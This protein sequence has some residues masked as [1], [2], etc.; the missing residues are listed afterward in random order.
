MSGFWED[1]KDI[2]KSKSRK[3]EEKQQK[4]SDVLQSENELV[5]KLAE[6]EEAYKSSLP[7]TEK[8]NL[9]EL[10]PTSLGLEKLIYDA[11]TDDELEERAQ[12]AVDYEKTAAK[13]KLDDSLKTAADKLS[14]QEKSAEKNLQDSYKEL[15][16]LYTDLKKKAENN[17]IKRGMARSSVIIGQLGNLD[18]AHMASAGEVE[19]AYN[20]I[21]SSINYEI[22]SLKEKKEKAYD[23]LDLKYAVELDKKITSLKSERDKTVADYQKY[24]NTIAEKET[25]Y[26]GQRE[27]DIAAYL[28]QLESDRLKSES[29]KREYEAQYGY[30]GAKQENYSQ[31]YDLAY[32]FYAS[33]SP[34]IAAAA[35]EAS[36][37]MRYYLGNYYDKLLSVLTND[38]S[39]SK[40]KYF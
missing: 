4:V 35:L 11:P 25:K 37:N 20:E 38:S 10:F 19:A 2:F 15:E 40:T 16:S 13:N 12:A 9:E 18:S 33:L 34:D 23:E 26:T 27:S 29:E 7:K 17:S 6:L 8:P 36:P 30:R 32:E 39:S 1:F 22:A 21:I 24:N 14:S 3:E 5:S 31:R 28:K